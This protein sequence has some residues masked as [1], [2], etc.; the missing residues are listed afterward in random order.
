MKYFKGLLIFCVVV[1]LIFITKKYSGNLKSNQLVFDTSK[2]VL[3]NYPSGDV[4]GCPNSSLVEF[5]SLT[6][7]DTKT[8]NNCVVAYSYLN[9]FSFKKD[10]QI[11]S[12]NPKDIE[13][14]KDKNNEVVAVAVLNEALISLYLDKNKVVRKVVLIDKDYS[15]VQCLDTTN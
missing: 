7:Q 3:K 12:I 2:C 14:T 5:S 15:V 6:V 9:G 11:V 10:S 1:I 13:I 4:Y 8:K